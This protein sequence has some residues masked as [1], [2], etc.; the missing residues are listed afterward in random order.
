[1][2]ELL[3]SDQILKEAYDTQTRDLQVEGRGG[4]IRLLCDDT[5]GCQHQLWVGTVSFRLIKRASA[6]LPLIS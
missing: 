4:V 5:E 3:E 1:M 6:A 2:P